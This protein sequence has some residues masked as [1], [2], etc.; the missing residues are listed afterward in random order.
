MQCKNCSG[1]EFKKTASGNFK[2]SYCSTLYYEETEKKDLSRILAKKNILIPTAAIVIITIIVYAAF[3]F[4]RGRIEPV[5]NSVNNYTFDNKE[6]L[7]EPMG[8]II[9]V[10]SI[11]DSIGNVY[12]LVMYKNSGKVS[13]NRPEVTIRLL[14]AKNEKIASG[15]GFAFIDKLNPG[16]ITPVYILVTNCPV[17]SKYELDFTPELPFIIPQGGVFGR[18]FSGEFFDVTLTQT[19]SSNNHKLRGKIKNSSEYDAQYVQIAAILYNKQD[20]VIGYGTTYI[21]EKKLKPGGF[22]FFEIY[23][24]TVTDKPEYYKL[25]FEGNVD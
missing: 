18:K 4:T 21:N 6:K 16:E 17:Y 24:T 2:C 8:E 22:D 23:L 13:L 7:P 11:P 1:N 3:S 9:S 20:K 14:S 5:D 19:D 25:Y 10:D 15:K 12:F